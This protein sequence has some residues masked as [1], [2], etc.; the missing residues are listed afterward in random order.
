MFVYAC[1]CVCVF[2]VCVCVL[3]G[4]QTCWDYANEEMHALL[5][6]YAARMSSQPA[7]KRF[8]LSLS[9][10]VTFFSICSVL[11]RK[12]KAGL[13]LVSGRSDKRHQQEPPVINGSVFDPENSEDKAW[14]ASEGPGT[15]ASDASPSS[16]SHHSYASE[17]PPHD[18][19]PPSLADIA[20]AS[21]LFDD[22]NARH[23]I[24]L[25]SIAFVHCLCI[26]ALFVFCRI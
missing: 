13:D 8:P 15:P 4:E 6:S 1:V 20:A 18:C 3:Q 16:G 5:E 25:V 2:N 19:L 10:F 26:M 14:V 9:M 17:S 24:A 12:R 7:T 22:G 21:L 23:G 11:N